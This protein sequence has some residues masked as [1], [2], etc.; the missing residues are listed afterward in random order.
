MVR[1]MHLMLAVLRSVLS[2]FMCIEAIGLVSARARAMPYGWGMA[3][4]TEST[5]CQMLQ[6]RVLRIPDL[7]ADF[8]PYR[9]LR[10]AANS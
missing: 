6:R 9:Q 8:S 10:N 3:L 5:R 4:A 7:T 2:A 1:P